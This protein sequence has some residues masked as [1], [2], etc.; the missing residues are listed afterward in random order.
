MQLFFM[1]LPYI[2]E[3]NKVHNKRKNVQKNVT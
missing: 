2:S 1:S 3:G